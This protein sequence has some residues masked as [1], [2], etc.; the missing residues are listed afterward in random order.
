MR[1]RTVLKVQASPKVARRGVRMVSGRRKVAFTSLL[2]SVDLPLS[3]SVTFVVA[4]PS[5]K[6]G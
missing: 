2:G 4:Q 5:K 6:Y 1:S 3:D